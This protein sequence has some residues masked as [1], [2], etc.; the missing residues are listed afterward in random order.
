MYN[1]YELI[2]VAISLY[3]RFSCSSTSRRRKLRVVIGLQYESMFYDTSQLIT[4]IRKYLQKA[5]AM[6]GIRH[7]ESRIELRFEKLTGAYGEHILTN[8]M[9]SI[10]NSNIAIFEVSDLNPNVMLELG[11][12][13]GRNVPPLLLREERSPPPPSDLEGFTWVAYEKSG[14]IIDEE[15]PKKFME[16]IERSIAKNSNGAK[17]SFI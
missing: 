16:M 5:I 13:L 4:N 3:H 1:L 15:F 12:A 9:R 2:N 7:P 11:V 10:G 14:E 17:W 8:I 6:Y